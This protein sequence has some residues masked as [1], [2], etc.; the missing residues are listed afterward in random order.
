[1]NPNLDF[2]GVLPTIPTGCWFFLECLSDGLGH[3]IILSYLLPLPGPTVPR[4]SSLPP[5]GANPCSNNISFRTLVLP[6][7]GT[8]LDR[9]LANPHRLAESPSLILRMDC[10]NDVAS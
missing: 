4:A 6:F 10:V 8:W 9:M 3:K 5:P 7:R 2:L 1:M